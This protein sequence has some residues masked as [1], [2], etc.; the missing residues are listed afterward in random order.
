MH[1]QVR[2]YQHKRIYLDLLV[3]WITLPFLN[4]CY[5]HS[6][7]APVGRNCWKSFQ[8]CC[9]RHS[10]LTLGPGWQSYP[11]DTG[12]WTRPWPHQVLEPLVVVAAAGL[13][14]VAAGPMQQ[15]C[16]G[17]RLELPLGL[18]ERPVEWGGGIDHSTV[19]HCGTD[20]F[21]RTSRTVSDKLVHEVTT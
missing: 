10:S 18:L 2:S 11:G 8:N 9:S 21:R 15:Y 4:G 20:H 13:H 16:V 6:T 7:F 3:P 1:Q 17:Q 19:L 5:C 12:L 14:T